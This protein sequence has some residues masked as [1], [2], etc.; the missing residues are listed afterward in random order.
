MELTLQILKAPM[1]ASKKVL[2]PA[3][4]PSS[5]DELCLHLAQLRCER[6]MEE[7]T[8]R[9]ECEA[10]LATAVDLR[11][12]RR[13]LEEETA[14][15]ERIATVEADVE[16]RSC[17]RSEKTQRT[18]LNELEEGQNELRAA[19]A[20]L[21]G[22][23]ADW[24]I[25]DEP[26]KR[27]ERSEAECRHATH[28]KAEFEEALSVSKQLVHRLRKKLDSHT[29][30][31]LRSSASTAKMA[32]RRGFQDLDQLRQEVR[33]LGVQ[34]EIAEQECGEE[35]KLLWDKKDTELP[36]LRA[37]ERE[38]QQLVAR[39]GQARYDRD[40][41]ER[42]FTRIINGLQ[43]HEARMEQQSQQLS[44]G[45]FLCRREGEEMVATMKDNDRNIAEMRKERWETE[46]FIEHLSKQVAKLE[47]ERNS[48]KTSLGH[49]PGTLAGIDHDVRVNV[50]TL[51]DATDAH[52][53]SRQ[54]QEA[55][56]DLVQD[57]AD[58]E[59]VV[60]EI[61]QQ[62]CMLQKLESRNAELRSEV[63]ACKPLLP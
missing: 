36:R 50:L 37:A 31:T 46:A 52:L 63:G 58:S 25:E 20:S 12:D 61:Q 11:A 33:R 56:E 14:R 60:E 9:K 45:L 34:V 1:E 53:I 49:E 48:L 18:L 27:L 32:G 54:E 29:E 62:E 16:E 13:M 26:E 19:S 22:V 35:A 4:K 6:D 21:R 59:A 24:V 23:A 40:H 2:W 38:R 44:E 55:C 28:C 8:F 7:V 47:D 30:D 43:E 17:A 10:L 57:E 51:V 41:L 39:L 3:E 5:H 42:N 15:W